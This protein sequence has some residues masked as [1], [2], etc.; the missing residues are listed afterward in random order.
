MVQV[1]ICGL[2]RLSDVET[3]V[4][5][6]ANYVGF[7]FYEQSPR[8]VSCSRA[9]E[10]CAIIPPGTLTV[11]L[12]VN[13]DLETLKKI[14][15]SVPFDM[16]QLHGNETPDDVAAIKDLT[17]LPVMKAISIATSED[18]LK[19]K[20][21]EGVA[22][23]ILCDAKPNPDAPTPGGNGIQFDWS[24]LQDY[25]WTKP[26]M[27]AGGLTPQNVAEAIRIT[28]T[29]QV[30]VSSGVEYKPGVKNPEKIKAFIQ[31][32]GM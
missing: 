27:L 3:A 9:I 32:A 25:Q 4:D 22:D 24:L 30:D 8:N 18:V 16:I 28:R 21:Y 7:V 26:W 12:F 11:G 14:T 19:I 20:N 10:M 29:Q 31:A 1:K 15:D 17:G 5:A 6:G 13:P 2:T 23:Q